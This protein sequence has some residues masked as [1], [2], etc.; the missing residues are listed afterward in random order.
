M[1]PTA[2]TSGTDGANGTLRAAA[3]VD[4][5]RLTRGQPAY[6]APFAHGVLVLLRG[7]ASGSVLL[8]RAGLLL[9]LAGLAQFVRELRHCP[10]LGDTV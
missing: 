1:A 7:H 6:W 5:A 2:R 9:T 3:G 8:I 10:L 4:P